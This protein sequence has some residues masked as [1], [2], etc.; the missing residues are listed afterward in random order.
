M[1][2]FRKKC[3]EKTK[4]KP[5]RGEFSLVL[6]W[7]KEGGEEKVIY[8]NLILVKIGGIYIYIQYNLIVCNLYIYSH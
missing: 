8:C 7:K 3:G 4:L 6:K 2:F 1:F 5:S